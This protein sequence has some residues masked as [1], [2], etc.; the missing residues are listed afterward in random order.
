M[1]LSQYLSANPACVEVDAMSR[2]CARFVAITAAAAAT[3][4]CVRTLNN[5]NANNNTRIHG[6]AGV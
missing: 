1:K 3:G 4:E 5:N 6:W 2:L